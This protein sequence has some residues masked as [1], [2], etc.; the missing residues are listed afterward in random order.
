MLLC[1]LGLTK[2]TDSGYTWK[3]K[4]VKSSSQTAI[5]AYYTRKI[6]TF[7]YITDDYYK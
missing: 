1:A 7:I 5:T 3:E 4:V 2:Y 6:S